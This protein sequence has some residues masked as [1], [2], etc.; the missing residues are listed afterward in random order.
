MPLTP[1]P[2]DFSGN[3]RGTS[4]DEILRGDLRP[5]ILDGQGGND[6]LY[7]YGGDDYLN[8]S[9]GDDLIVGGPGNDTLLA[10]SGVDTLVFNS[11]FAD[12]VFTIN[13][14]SRNQISTVEGLDTFSDDFEYMMFD[15]VLYSH[16]EYVQDYGERIFVVLPYYEGYIYQ[17]GR[18]DNFYQGAGR[19]W[20]GAGDDTVI[21]SDD[22]DQILGQTGSDFLSGGN[23]S[24]VL[25]GGS[26]ADVLLGGEGFDFLNGGWGFD[27]LNGGAG[28]DRFY[29]SGNIHHGT[30]WVDD[31]SASEDD[32]FEFPGFAGTGGHF[33]ADE[34]DFVV[35]FT[36]T[37][38]AGNDETAEAFIGY[39]PTGQILWAVVDG[40]DESE[41]ILRV[42]MGEFD[43]LA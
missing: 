34:D 30:D 29:H 42:G 11:D 5:N 38:G 7:G 15:D 2:L 28:A 12:A 8:G 6:E 20:A 27:R 41:L 3:A 43:L 24:D 26:H 39:I 37:H 23:G 40:A 36:I 18:L 16:F 22:S 19:I 31:Y 9:F 1:I 10:E 13:F 25:S 33:Q 35:H 21:G 4:L 14:G 17:G 32:V